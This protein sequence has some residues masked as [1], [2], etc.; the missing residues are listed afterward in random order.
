MKTKVCYCYKCR[1]DTV[2]ELVHRE[3]VL[4]GTGPARGMLAVCSFG[5]SELV[6]QATVSRKYQCERCGEIRKG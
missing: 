3:T 2:H 5:F 1:R 6:N 4:S